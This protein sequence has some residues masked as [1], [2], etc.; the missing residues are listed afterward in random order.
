[1]A[2]QVKRK[3]G[4]PSHMQ[5]LLE[6][7]LKGV[8]KDLIAWQ[9][10]VSPSRVATGKSQNWTILLR[11]FGN[12]KPKDIKA[13]LVGVSY[14]NYALF[15]RRAG[16]QPPIDKIMAWMRIRGIQ[17]TG[18]H[19]L[20]D[21]AWFI[22]KQIGEMGTRSLKLKDDVV[23]FFYSRNIQIA[24]DNHLPNI[25]DETAQALVDDFV[26]KSKGFKNFKVTT[27]AL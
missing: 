12:N 24:I 26:D 18:N 3:P 1:M 8:A 13:S 21:A 17:P 27:K 6:Q 19:T 16:K 5:R 11:P 4:R 20:R 10:R 15:G 23:D 7:A 14:I 2:I 22:A 25:T 9:K